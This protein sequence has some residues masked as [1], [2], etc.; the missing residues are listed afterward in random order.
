[1]SLPKELKK[2]NSVIGILDQLI[3]MCMS[4]WAQHGSIDLDPCS[5]SIKT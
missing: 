2:G 5:H 4:R 3:C 1:L